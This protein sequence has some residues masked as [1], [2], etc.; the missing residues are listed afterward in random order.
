MNNV[1][2]HDSADCAN[3]PK[4]IALIGKYHSQD[5]AES[6]RT[7]ASYLHERGMTVL[8]EEETARNV[9]SQLELRSW[10]SGSFAWLGAHADLAIVVGGDG[11]MLNAARQLARYRVPLVGV[12]QGRLGFMTDISRDDML[13]A[14]NDLLDGR[15]VP[16]TRML[17]EAE[18]LRDERPVGAP[19][20]ALNDVVVDKGAIGRM[21]EFGLAVDGEF[22]YHLRADGLIVATSTGSTAYALSANGPILHPQVS[23]IALVPLCPHALTNRP[24]LVG[25]R[26]EIEI[27]IVHGTDSRVHFDGQVTV[28]L[29][30]GDCVRIRRSEYSI[31]L[32]H[33]PDHS[34]FAMLRQKLHWSERPKEH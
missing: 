22:I 23:A 30:N 33:P 9:M 20:L 16:E 18:V 32:L 6:I 25:D 12:N 1:F 26:N 3:L 10:A 2:P 13:A 27:R 15:F 19:H 11:T 34:Y 21:I 14:M 24:I 29:E 4:T 8:I 7:L 17:L 31:C 5:I 28:D